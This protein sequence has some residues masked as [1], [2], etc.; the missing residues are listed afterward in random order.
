MAGSCWPAT[1]SGFDALDTHDFAG[2]A[3]TDVVLRRYRR[4]EIEALMEQHASLA[5]VL[6]EMA[7]RELRAAC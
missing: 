4:R 2:Q 7:A 1:A 5:Q 6:Q 3:V